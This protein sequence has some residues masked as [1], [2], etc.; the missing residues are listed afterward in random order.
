M[1]TEKGFKWYFYCK[2]CQMIPKQLHHLAKQ[3]TFFSA[4]LFLQTSA[5]FIFTCPNHNPTCRK[6]PDSNW[7]RGEI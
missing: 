3:E 2:Y 4:Q 1:L 7:V 5:V 6:K